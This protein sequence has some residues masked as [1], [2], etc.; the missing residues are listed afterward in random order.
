MDREEKVKKL[1]KMTGQE[2]VRKYWKMYTKGEITMEQ[3]QRAL[4]FWRKV[5]N[6]VSEDDIKDI[7]G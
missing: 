2:V 6:K 5:K 1:K 7:L 4:R 3:Y